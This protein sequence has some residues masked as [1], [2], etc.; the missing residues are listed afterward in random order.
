M[1]DCESCSKRHRDIEAVEKCLLRA[2]KRAE[3]EELRKADKERRQKNLE[4]MPVEELVRQYMLKGHTYDYKKGTYG[5]F[6]WDRIV[7]KLN[8]DYPIREEG[9]YTLWEVVE[10]DS[11]QLLGKWGFMVLNDIVEARLE[12]HMLGDYV[13]RQPLEAPLRRP[14]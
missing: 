13:T 12:K 14:A 5:P 4:A 7:T 6:Q 9:P 8:K 2:E 1:I 11:I 3:R 10:I